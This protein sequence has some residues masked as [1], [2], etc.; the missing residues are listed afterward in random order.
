MGNLLVMSDL[1]W[2]IITLAIGLTIR[3][4]YERIKRNEDES[5][6]SRIKDA[7]Y[8]EKF[9]NINKALERGDGRF[10]Q[11]SDKLDNLTGEVSKLNTHIV[12]WVERVDNRK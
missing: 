2:G 3:N 9:S 5:R 8:D 7:S 6:Q 12:K 4:L 11:L 10:Q 1:V